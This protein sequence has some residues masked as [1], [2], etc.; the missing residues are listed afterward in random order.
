MVQPAPLILGMQWHGYLASYPYALGLAILLLLRNLA[1]RRV[2]ALIPVIT[3]LFFWTA[4][5]QMFIWGCTL[6]GAAALLFRRPGVAVWRR[7]G[8]FVAAAFAAVVVPMAWLWTASKFADE[9]WMGSHTKASA[10]QNHAEP[11]WHAVPALFV[12]N[13]TGLPKLDAFGL[14]L[15]AGV[16]IFF[17]PAVV[18]VGIWCARKRRFAALAFLI[19]CIVLLAPYATGLMTIV[20]V[21]PWAGFRWTWKLTM[22]ALPPLAVAA[23]LAVRPSDAD[24]AVSVEVR[25]HRWLT[26]ALGASALLVSVRGTAFDLANY[27]KPHATVGVAGIVDEGARLSKAL[28]AHARGNSRTLESTF[29]S[30]IKATRAYLALLGNLP[31][32]EPGLESAHV[33]EPLENDDV[34]A[35][36]MRLGPPWRSGVVPATLFAKDSAPTLAGLRAVGVTTLVALEASQLPA[37]LRSTRY[38]GADGRT[39]W[40]RDI[41]LDPSAAPAPYPLLDAD[42]S[43]AADGTLLVKRR[44]GVR[45]T[46][47]LVWAAA[48]DGTLVARAEIPTSFMAL[49]AAALALAVAMWLLALRRLRVRP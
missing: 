6:V 45:T 10:L 19:F 43:R 31:M 3:A 24:D 38:E 40:L 16:G 47:P 36:H 1:D 9:N 21:G 29:H 15:G 25:G 26:L 46:R 28:P 8:S 32:L 30:P 41:R 12:G 7:V 42:G 2:L 11:L 33:Y 44:D 37:D 20:S 34:S 13:L 49:E 5:P 22:I 27:W 4:H 23:A 14:D 48:A 39:L 35:A 17:C 18:V